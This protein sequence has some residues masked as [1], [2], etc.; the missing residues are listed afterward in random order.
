VSDSDDFRMAFGVCSP[1][2]DNKLSADT[3][4]LVHVCVGGRPLSVW[5][6]QTLVESLQV[7][8]GGG[9]DVRNVFREMKIPH[10]FCGES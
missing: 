4:R 9:V 6:L 2:D 3:R 5:R 1:S 7:P 10:S 8:L